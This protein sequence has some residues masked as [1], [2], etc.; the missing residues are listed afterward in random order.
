MKATP[1][2]KKVT[3]RRRERE[4]Q[5][6]RGNRKGKTVPR[7]PVWKRSNMVPGEHSPLGALTSA[8]GGNDKDDDEDDDDLLL[9]LCFSSS[10]IDLP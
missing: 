10:S 3:E 1:K 4:R 2:K 5:G 6:D 8:A 9:L 7:W